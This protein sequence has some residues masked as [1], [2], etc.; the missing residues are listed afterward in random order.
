M[1]INSDLLAFPVHQLL[2]KESFLHRIHQLLPCPEVSMVLQTPKDVAS[3]LILLSAQLLALS[4]GSVLASGL[5]AKQFLLGIHVTLCYKP[6]LLH[7]LGLRN[8]KAPLS[9]WVVHCVRWHAGLQTITGVV[10]ETFQSSP[11]Q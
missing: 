1:A 3:W 11:M 6:M 10:S 9:S 8:A 4:F 5:S 2:K 7:D